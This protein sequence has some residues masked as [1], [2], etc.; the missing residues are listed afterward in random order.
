MNLGLMD[1]RASILSALG[2][3]AACGPVVTP[4]DGSG[5]AEGSDSST[6]TPTESGPPG[7]TTL[8]DGTASASEGTSTTAEPP[9]PVTCQAST[10][11]DHDRRLLRAHG[12]LDPADRRAAHSEALAT[13]L[14]PCAA[15]LVAN[16]SASA[17][18]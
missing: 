15:A 13:V 9:P 10:P 5:S 3:V 8:Q 12:V 14:R 2:L 1:L 7:A 16:A 6:A 11:I 18:A 17:S 4:S